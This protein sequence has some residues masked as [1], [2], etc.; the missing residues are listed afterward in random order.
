MNFAICSKPK[1]FACAHREAI[2]FSPGPGCWSELTSSVIIQRPSRT[3]FDRCE[4]FW[5]TTNCYETQQLRNDPLVEQGG[6]C[7]RGG[8]AGASRLPG[9]RRD[10]T[11]S[12][13]ER[14]RRHQVLDQN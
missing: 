11:A 7:L 3:R 4:G 8:C 10:A 9:P 13:Q 6:R 1:A 12:H 5:H 2:T 14:R